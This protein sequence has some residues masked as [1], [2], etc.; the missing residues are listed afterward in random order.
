MPDR[1][2]AARQM[3]NSAQTSRRRSWNI[4]PL[5]IPA[6]PACA[7][8]APDTPAPA[9]RETAVWEP[10][11]YNCCR[12][13]SYSHCYCSRFHEILDSRATVVAACMAGRKAAV[14]VGQK[15]G[16]RGEKSAR[17]MMARPAAGLP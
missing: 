2:A 12:F 7:A 6:E 13:H 14:V 16:A 17:M 3:D 10:A 9:R 11:H 15:A 8:A 5:F 4:L 1:P